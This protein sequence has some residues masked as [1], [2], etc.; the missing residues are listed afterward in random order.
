MIKTWP[1]KKTL[2][3]IR[4]SLLCCIC[5]L[6]LLSHTNVANAS[7]KIVLQLA[8][9]HQFQF[10]GYYA[11]MHKGY[12]RQAGLDVIIVE[13]GE[14]RFAR[15]EVLGGRAQ[16]GI[17]GAELVLHRADGNPFVVL[18]PI[19][20]HSPSILLTRE[21][22]NI[23]NLQDLIGKR[24]MLLPGKKDADILAAFFNEGVAIDSIKRMDQSYNLNDLIEGRTDAV[25]AYLTNE[26]WYLE[27]KGIVPKIISPQTYGVDFYSDCLFTTAQEIEKHPNRVEKILEASLRGW[28][29][30]MAHPEEII[31]ILLT[32]YGLE[33]KRDHLRYEAD[34]IR[35]IML[36]GLV[37]IGHMNPGRWRHIVNTYVKLGMIDPEFSLEGFLYDPHPEVDYTRLK[38]VVGVSISISLLVSIGVLILLRLNKRLSAEIGE[39]RFVEESLRASEKE[40]RSTLNDLLVGVVVHASDTSILLSNREAENILGLTYEQLSGKK[41]IDPEWNFV[42]EDSTIMKVEQYPVSKVF[43]TKKQ[44]HDYVVG[45]KRPDRDYVTWVIVNAIPVFSKDS[46]LEKVIVNFIDITALKQAEEEKDRLASQLRQAAKIEAVG[47]LAGGIA[48]DFNNILGIIVGNAELAMD[49]VSEWNPARNNL[50]E[51]KTASMRAKNVV[52]QLLSFSRKSEQEKRPIK[53]HTI[54]KESVQLL[55]ASIPSS[56]EF[57]SNIPTDLATIMA[58]PTQI[59]QVAINLGTNAAHAMEENGGIL[60][61]SLDEVEL[62]EGSS[63]GYLHVNSWPYIQLTVSDTGCGIDPEIKDRIFDPYFSTKEVGK[64]SGIG[65]AVVHGIVKDHDGSISVSSEPAKGTT[66]KVLFP[67]INEMPAQE[68]VTFEELPKGKENVLFVDDEKALTKMGQQVLERLGYKVEVSNNPVEAL[69][70]IRSNPNRFDL[71]ITDM[72]MPQMTGDKLVKEILKIRSDMPIILCTGFSEKINRDSAGSIGIRKYIEKPLDK[73]ELSIVIREVLD[74]KD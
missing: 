45:I 1:F 60:E 43:S 33:K 63:A 70:R 72:T 27:Q 53:I 57:R 13:G 68:N 69:E 67:V 19:F 56:V 22:S 44:L 25:S 48:H 4:L 55:R 61:M 15:E 42:H 18:A 52:R 54:I 62:D 16:Y 41:T 11:A 40:Y 38:W 59:H 37:Q 71:V 49:D 32:D 14:G 23:S 31:D 66:V 28:E 46:E 12:Y 17:A 50:K 65:L 35:N 10:A 34:S 73:R 24:V 64:G 47:T 8:W 36:P 58:D 9:K 51:I 30:A 7:N 29:Y 21:D 26:P 20:Q 74:K 6:I 2:H 39:R 5:L 3:P